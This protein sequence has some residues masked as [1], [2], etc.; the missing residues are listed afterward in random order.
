MDTAGAARGASDDGGLVSAFAPR[1]WYERDL[2]DKAAIASVRI[3]RLGRAEQDRVESR[4]RKAQDDWDLAREA[5]VADL[6]RLLDSDPARAV[7]R[8]RALSEGC[9]SLAD[10]W[11]ALSVSSYTENG[12]LCAALGVDPDLAGDRLRAAVAARLLEQPAAAWRA[13]LAEARVVATEVVTDLATLHETPVATH[14]LD[15]AECVFV[16]APWRFEA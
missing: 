11:L 8:L 15:R 3:S 7:P 16:T 5:E 9:D 6:T 4:Q 12:R 2:L 1:D 13:R 14:A 10:A